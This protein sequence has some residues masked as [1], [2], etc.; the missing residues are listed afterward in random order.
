MSERLLTPKE[1]CEQL[2]ISRSGLQE[3]LRRGE[4]PGI[5]VGRLWRFRP[6]GIASWIDAQEA[7]IRKEREVTG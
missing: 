7:R 4:I 6:E 1:V 3:M 5:R 2:A